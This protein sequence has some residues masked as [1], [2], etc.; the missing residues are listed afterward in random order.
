MAVTALSDAELLSGA[1]NGDEAAFTELY[2]RHHDAARRLAQGY[3]RLGDPDDLVNGAFERVLA[4]LR[5]GSGPTDSF[6]AYL[7]VT[8]RR[9]AMEHGRRDG[10]GSDEPLD[11][12]PEPVFAV[13][14]DR[15]L[16]GAE[17]AI[18]AQ[19]FES[20]PNAWQTVLWQTAVE[21]K[22]PKDFAGAVG[23]TPNAAAALAYRA[24]E[25]LR[26]AYLQAHLQQPARNGCEPHRSRLGSY[27]RGGLSRRHAAATTEHLAS[28]EACRE[29]NDELSDVNRMLVRAVAPVFLLASGGKLASGFASGSTSAAASAPA[30][31]PIS[32]TSM[33]GGAVDHVRRFGTVAGGAI[34]AAVAAVALGAVTLLPHD[35]GPSDR[36]ADIDVQADGGDIEAVTAGERTVTSDDTTTSSSTTATTAPTTTVAGDTTT[37]PGAADDGSPTTTAGNV[38]DADVEAG[39]GPVDAGVDADVG[40]GPDGVAVDT[41]VDL[42]VDLRWA[43]GLLPGTGTLVADVVNQ[44]PVTATN[45]KIDLDLSTSASISGASTDCPLST[46][47]LISGV[48]SLLRSVTCPLTSLA[49][50]GSSSLSVPLAV[51][52]DATATVTVSA[53]GE[54]LATDSISLSA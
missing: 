50:G 14:G 22:Q 48:I 21:G 43:R 11:E 53:N 24:R 12:V 8:L 29:L 6:R 20:L 16:E 37:V 9:L 40:I 19:A 36:G 38:V 23:M 4:A 35:G 18:I 54:V 33:A 25:R 41:S 1:R 51:I 3:K 34:A 2:V 5:R 13:A 27:V 49:S 46:E 47:G 17:R 42:G 45:V 52:G 28:C 31:A 39:V 30:A 26:Q 32:V 15:E 44:S 7:F 10:V